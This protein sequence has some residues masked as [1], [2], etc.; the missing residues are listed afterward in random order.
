[1]LV[2]HVAEYILHLSLMYFNP[3]RPT[4][5]DLE[6]APYTFQGRACVRP[7][8]RC[9]EVTFLSDIESAMRMNL[10]GPISVSFS[11][12]VLF[13]VPMKPWF[14]SARLTIDNLD[15]H[16]EMKNGNVFPVWNWVDAELKDEADKVEKARLAEITRR[17][18]RASE[19]SGKEI[20]AKH[21][22]GPKRAPR[23]PPGGSSFLAIQDKQPEVDSDS[24]TNGSPKPTHHIHASCI[25]I[26][27]YLWT[28]T[29]VA[30]ATTCYRPG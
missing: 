28:F 16:L 9:G 25:W 23:K 19:P 13:N 7:I 26:A 20:A 27:T 8:L 11:R 15:K 6:M 24:E 4:F 5:G 10:D 14:P 17:A 2:L 29:C 21:Q 1:M 30:L 22:P 18:K 3:R 12:F